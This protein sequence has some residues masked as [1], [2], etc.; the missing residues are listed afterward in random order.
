[1][2]DY[3]KGS[4]RLG[5]LDGSSVHRKESTVRDLIH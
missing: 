4:I 1:M 5:Y 3:V 2:D